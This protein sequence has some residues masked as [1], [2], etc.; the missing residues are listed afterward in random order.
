[1]NR[2]GIS[3][4]DEDVTH[5]PVCE[6]PVRMLRRGNL[7]DHYEPLSHMAGWDMAQMPTLDADTAE[8]LRE[9]RAGKKTIAMVGMAE[10]SCNF[11]PFYDEEVEIWALNEMHAFPFLKRWDRWFQIHSK[12]SW[13]RAIAKRGVENHAHFL[14][15][16]HGKP[17]YMQ[18][19]FEE[20]PDAVAYPLREVVHEVFHN[21]KR[22]LQK[23]IPKYFTSTIAY[24]FGVAILE[25]VDRVEIYGVE[26]SDAVEYR[27]QK[28]NTEFFMGFAMAKGIEV[29][30]PE[31]CSLMKSN[32]YGEASQG[33]GW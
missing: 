11:A 4:K 30:V 14:M 21:F 2:H 31:K 5:C 22:G 15:Q 26:M 24:M 10:T 17:I 28:A 13:T 9:E 20:V 29:W 27:D 32:L 33:E 8:K 23:Q 19:E 6:S 12:K 3:Y 7:L 16:E 25:K 1:M 18:H